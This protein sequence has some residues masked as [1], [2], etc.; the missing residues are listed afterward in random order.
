MQQCTRD[1]TTHDFRPPATCSAHAHAYPAPQPL[2]CCWHIPNSTY[3]NHARARTHT[4]TTQERV[5][6]CGSVVVAVGGRPNELP[7]EGGEL[8]MT[9]DDIF[10]L[11]TPPG[12]TLVVG[13]SY[14]ALEC[15]GACTLVHRLGICFTSYLVVQKYVYT[16]ILVKERVMCVQRRFRFAGLM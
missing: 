1:L 8:A 12:K 4:Y 10:S 11:K 9:S 2:C 7:C 3:K 15:A 13:A 6:S 16:G 14:V 5:L